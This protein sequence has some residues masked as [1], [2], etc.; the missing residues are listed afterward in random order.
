MKKSKIEELIAKGRKDDRLSQPYLIAEAGVNHGGNFDL[1]KRLIYE[2]KEG[3]AD[4]IKFQTYK[5]K[6][7]AAEDSP[8]YWDLNQEP[9]TNQRDLF[10]K[11][12]KF[13]KKE[14]ERLSK[15]CEKVGITF[16]STPFDFASARFLND[17]MPVFKIASADITN[18]PFIDYIS[19]F[20]KPVIISTGASYLWEISRATAIIEKKG[21]PFCLMHCILN[22]PTKKKDANLGM[23][24]DLRRRFPARL[25]G[26][27]DHTL[28]DPRL[29]V[30]QLAWLLGAS[31]IEKHF[32]YNKSLPG[33]DHYH[34]MDK[35]DIKAFKIAARNWL[36]M[37]GSQKKYP[38]S[39][40]FKARKNA[41]RS[42]VAAKNLK[43][44][45]VLSRKDVTFLRPGTGITPTFLN[46]II[47][48]RVEKNIKAG[49]ILSLKCFGIKVSGKD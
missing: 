21:I 20:G 33:N 41:R 32:T 14:Y 43:R 13:W 45:H 15:I 3:G 12:D 8:S 22:Y 37:I 18:L 48:A 23:I 38:I 34:A 24:I 9:S 10:K 40:E 4:A 26:Y 25:I 39:S 30:L 6:T 49:Q 19:S 16:L 47:G 11:Y 27:S 28:P 44:G 17:L 42:I 46:N 2:A 31:I 29:S 35:D 5:A 7:L 1:A 36:M